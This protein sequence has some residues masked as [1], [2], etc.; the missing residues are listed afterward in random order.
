MVDRYRAAG[1]KAT[2]QYDATFP[3]TFTTVRRGSRQVMGAFG[4]GEI[5]TV[6]AIPGVPVCE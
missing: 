6:L 4:E 2:G 5:I 1:S 3:G